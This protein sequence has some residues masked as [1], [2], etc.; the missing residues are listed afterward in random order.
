MVV[1][2]YQRRTMALVGGDFQGKIDPSEG[3]R[4]EGWKDIRTVS[5]RKRSKSSELF[6]LKPLQNG[7]FAPFEVSP[8]ITRQ[9]EGR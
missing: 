5:F 1:R 6:I 2:Q 4:G 7:L 8:A 3:N 9:L